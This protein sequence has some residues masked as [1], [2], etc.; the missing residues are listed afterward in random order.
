MRYKVVFFGKYKGGKTQLNRRIALQEKFEFQYEPGSTVGADFLTREIASDNTVNLWDTAGDERFQGMSSVFYKG[1]DVG[2]FCID[3]TEVINEQEFNKSIQEFRE[4][5][6]NAPIICVGTK[7]DLATADLNAFK[8]I[9]SKEIA[10][11]IITSAKNGDNVNELFSIITQ[12]CK[13]KQYSLWGE[14]K[15]RLLESLKELP[16]RKKLS[17]NQELFKLSRV[18]FV[19]TNNSSVTPLHKAKAI[20]DFTNNCK[21]ILDC[22]HPNVLHVVLSVAAAAAALIVT[23]LI[24]F[25]IGVACSCWAGPGAFFAGILS[26]Y[27][28]AL[29]VASSS[30][31]LGAVAGGLAV[32][33]LFKPSKEMKALNEFTAEVSSLNPA[34]IL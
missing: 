1:A 27:T 5:A 19:D 25:T 6:P 12:L 26:G 33:S 28:A 24:G 10:H 20:D 31:A 17:I 32:Y 30:T 2:I 13:L 15:A 4:F 29:T 21:D 22:Q 11:F 23:A 34:V 9:K 8:K 16:D 7:S 18:I 14:A 3:L